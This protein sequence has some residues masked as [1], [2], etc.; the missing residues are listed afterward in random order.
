MQG[1]WEHTDLKGAS[2]AYTAS[3][4]SDFIIIRVTL[5]Y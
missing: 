1:M 3:G 4:T 2:S 5:L